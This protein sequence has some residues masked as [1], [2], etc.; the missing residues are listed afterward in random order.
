MCHS[1]KNLKN[2]TRLIATRPVEVSPTALSL[3]STSSME[4]P[5]TRPQEEI[6]Q[7]LENEI[8]LAAFVEFQIV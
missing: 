1:I 5:H 8:N 6:A 7:F 2:D 3:T 4:I